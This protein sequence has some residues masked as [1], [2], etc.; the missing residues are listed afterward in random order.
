MQCPGVSHRL[1][2]Q[3]RSFHWLDHRPIFSLK[4]QSVFSGMVFCTHSQGRTMYGGIRTCFYI[5]HTH[6]ADPHSM[7]NIV[8]IISYAS[9]VGL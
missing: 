7:Y 8:A 2:T 6:T 9:L 5:V 3:V 1:G 4:P